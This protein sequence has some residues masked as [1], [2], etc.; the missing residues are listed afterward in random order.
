MIFMSSEGKL[1]G[2]CVGYVPNYEL[3]SERVTMTSPKLF[4]F[5][6]QSFTYLFN[7]HL[8][9]I[10]YVPGR[11]EYAGDTKIYQAESHPQVIH[12]L[13]GT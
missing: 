5:F 11:T 4:D 10:Y 6:S 3:V 9:R 1:C 2:I 8:L 12:S 13:L 7:K